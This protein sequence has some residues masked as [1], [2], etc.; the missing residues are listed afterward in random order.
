MDNSSKQPEFDPHAR[1]FSSRDWT[2]MAY[3]AGLGIVPLIV[4]LI[5][6]YFLF[7]RNPNFENFAPAPKSEPHQESGSQTSQ[8]LLWHLPKKTGA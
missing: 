1:E 2:I 4:I 8:S 6:I 3:F 7:A 5:V